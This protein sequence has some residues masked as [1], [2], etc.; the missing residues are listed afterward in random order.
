MGPAEQLLCN[1]TVCTTPNRIPSE[2]HDH[3]TL[4]FNINITVR[5]VDSLL[6]IQVAYSIKVNDFHASSGVNH[7]H[8][9]RLRSV[10]ARSPAAW[11]TMNE[12]AQ[13]AGWILNDWS[14]LT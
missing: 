4:Y 2:Q 11:Q 7:F 12:C 5:I 6:Y 10:E 13:F 1:C 3:Y 9:E 14:R 8:E